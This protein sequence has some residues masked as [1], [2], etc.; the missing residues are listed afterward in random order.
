MT[1]VIPFILK[2]HL[3][4]SDICLYR[5]KAMSDTSDAK[6]YSLINNVYKRPKKFDF[7]DRVR[8]GPLDL[9]GLKSLH[10]F[11]TLGERMV[12][13]TFPVVYLTIKLWKVL[14]WK[15]FTENH[16]KNGQQ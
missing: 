12:S 13:I 1:K 7:P 5:N 16:I 10:E 6:L 4:S 11:V 14:V 8:I 3:H 15:I 9:S 2:Q